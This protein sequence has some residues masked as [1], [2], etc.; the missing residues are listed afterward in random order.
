MSDSRWPPAFDPDPY[1]LSQQRKDT[2]RPYRHEQ[3]R[4]KYPY[5]DTYPTW[6]DTKRIPFDPDFGPPVRERFETC[7]T[8]YDPHCSDHRTP[9]PDKEKFPVDPTFG[10]YAL[11]VEDD[12]GS[13]TSHETIHDLKLPDKM[14]EDGI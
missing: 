12:G 13:R 1:L 11:P 2:D 8:P 9:D 5:R 7:R 14:R 4:E 6:D 10:K 3:Q